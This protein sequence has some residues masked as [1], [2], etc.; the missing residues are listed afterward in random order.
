V[1]GIKQTAFQIKNVNSGLCMDVAGSSGEGS[2]GM[3]YC[4]GNQDQ[5]FYIRSRGAVVS[6]GRL[7]NEA[8]N[9]CMDVAGSSGTGNIATYNCDGGADQWWSYF[10]NGEIVN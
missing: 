4:D 3:Y 1:G 6:T 8:S 5:S 2:I 9:Q 10:Q 7:Q